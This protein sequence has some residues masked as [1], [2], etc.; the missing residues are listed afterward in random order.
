MICRQLQ[1]AVDCK[2]FSCACMQRLH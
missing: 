1:T 2:F